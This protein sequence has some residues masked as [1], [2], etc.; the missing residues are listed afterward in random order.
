MKK[1]Y[2]AG[3]ITGQPYAEELFN[4]A[5]LEVKALFSDNI[6]IINPMRLP[7]DHDKKWNS[8]MKECIAELVYCDYIYM[9]N[10]WEASRGARVEIELAKELEIT[11]YHQPR[12]TLKERTAKLLD[13]YSSLG[14]ID[15]YNLLASYTFTPHYE[16]KKNKIK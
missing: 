10:G 1:I 14:F 3:P 13:L 15:K 2:L 8:Y 5:E 9:L 12:Q 16:S 4:F 11:I 7:H 6:E